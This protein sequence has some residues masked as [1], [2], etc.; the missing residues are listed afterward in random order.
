MWDPKSW[1]QKL[2]DQG[3]SSKEAREKAL[4]KA[5]L[6][7]EFLGEHIA[8]RILGVVDNKTEPIFMYGPDCVDMKSGGALTCKLDSVPNARRLVVT[9]AI[10]A[11]RDDLNPATRTIVMHVKSSSAVPFVVTNVEYEIGIPTGVRIASQWKE[12][13]DYRP[14]VKGT[15]LKKITVVAES[16]QNRPFYPDY[17]LLFVPLRHLVFEGAVANPKVAGS[18]LSY[19]SL[20]ELKDKANAVVDKLRKPDTAAQ[21]ADQLVPFVVGK[22]YYQFD[23]KLRI[24]NGTGS[25]AYADYIVGDFGVRGGLRGSFGKVEFQFETEKVYTPRVSTSTITSTSTSTTTNYTP[26]TTATRPPEGVISWNAGT[27]TSFFC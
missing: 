25:K 23:D 20:Q 1:R 10:D 16:P 26:T 7:W 6:F 19:N 4:S 9:T 3:L 22:Y 14:T 15:K 13:L 11:S 12:V 5:N 24:V 21:V 17:N 18:S 2:R 8:K 27:T